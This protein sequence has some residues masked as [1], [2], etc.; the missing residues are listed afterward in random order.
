MTLRFRGRL[1][2]WLVLSTFF[3]G[4]GSPDL[5]A[6][7]SKFHLARYLDEGEAHKLL[8]EIQV[9]CCDARALPAGDTWIAPSDSIVPTWMHSRIGGNVREELVLD[10]FFT[11][12]R[13][14]TTRWR[15]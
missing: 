3:V 13:E 10:A 2:L 1:P 8:I 6:T 9:Q 14:I 11:H 15:S 4:F 5:A 12:P 7:I